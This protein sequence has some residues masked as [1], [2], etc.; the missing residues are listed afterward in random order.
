MSRAN[1]EKVDGAGTIGKSA[2]H[3][4]RVWVASKQ[5]RKWIRSSR[6]A[7]VTVL[8]V[9]E[10]RAYGITVH[11]KELSVHKGMVDTHFLHI[12]ELNSCPGSCGGLAVFLLQCH[13]ESSKLEI[14]PN[15]SLSQFQ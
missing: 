8:R 2:R 15:V 5:A 1:F 7:A 6:G 12:D 9:S 11:V 4:Y 13:V 14:H 10:R 3:R